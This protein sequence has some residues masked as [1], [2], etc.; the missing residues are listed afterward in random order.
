MAVVLGGCNGAPK[1]RTPGE[2]KATGEKLLTVN[3]DAVVTSD[4]VDAVTRFTSEAE[5][6]EHK[7]TGRYVTMVEQIGLGEVLYREALAAKLDKDPEILK[8]L[9]MK[10]RETL[11]QELLAKRVEERIT[12]EAIQR[13][14]DERG[15]Q[16]KRPQARARHILVTEE[17]LANEIMEKLGKGEDF[18]TLA[19][20]FTIDARTRGEGGNLGW[21]QRDKLIEEVAAVAFDAEIG[22]PQGPVQTR[23][24]YHIIEPLER[25]DAIPLEEVRSELEN[26]LRQK[27]FAAVIEE[28]KAGLKYERFGEALEVHNAT[29]AWGVTGSDAPPGDH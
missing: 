24:G 7:K 16:Y 11:A 19:K 8:A 1:E 27:E 21:F 15:V 9:A 25:R 2:F 4:M 6:A 20:E 5:L 23:F 17:A 29:D 3:G 12:D 10:E 18:A 13:L 26:E 14:Y 28:V 22:K